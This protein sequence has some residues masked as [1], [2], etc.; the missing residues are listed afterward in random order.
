MALQAFGKLTKDDYPSL[1]V[2]TTIYEIAENGRSCYHRGEA[3]RALGNFRKVPEDCEKPW[4]FVAKRLKNENWFV[5]SAATEVLGEF[6]KL[7]REHVDKVAEMLDD[8]VYEVRLMAIKALGNFGEHSLRY[9][10]KVVAKLSQ[11]NEDDYA[12]FDQREQL[13]FAVGNTL[14]RILKYMEVRETVHTSV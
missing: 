12:S 1:S 7:A 4:D 11:E 3:L 8:P 5:R 9:V 14:K 6:G 2:L 13:G 10:G